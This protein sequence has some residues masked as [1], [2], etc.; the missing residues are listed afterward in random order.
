M[1]DTHKQCETINI[2][3]NF[4]KL[5]EIK[6]T[7]HKDDSRNEKYRIINEYPINGLNLGKY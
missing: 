2:F 3:D 6:I 5:S 7:I 1:F 4:D